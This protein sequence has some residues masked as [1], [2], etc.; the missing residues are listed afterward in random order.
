MTTPPADQPPPLSGRKLAAG[1]IAG[2]GISGVKTMLQLLTLPVLASLLRPA[3][4]G[5]FALAQP[6]VGFVGLLADAGLGAS[7]VREPESNEDVWSTAWWFLLGLGIFLALSVCGAGAV[8]GTLAHQPR[9]PALMALMSLSMIGVTMSVVPGARLAR[10]GRLVI[11]A[12]V[13]LGAI[14]AGFAVAVLCS[15]AGAGAFSFAAQGVTVTAVRTIGINAVAFRLPRWRF[16]PRLL[17]GHLHSGGAQLSGR[18]IDLVDRLGGNAVLQRTIGISD[19]GSFS[20]ASQVVRFA[21]EAVGNTCWSLLFLQAARTDQDHTLRLHE[22]LCRLQGLLLLP[23]C[24]IGAVAAPGVVRLILGERWVSA[25]GLIAIMLPFFALNTISALA[26]AILLARN[27]YS[28]ALW[29][30]A[31]GAGLR[32][33]VTACGAWIGLRG[34]AIGTDAILLVQV[35]VLTMAARKAVGIGPRVI[36]RQLIGP[37]IAGSLGAAAFLAASHPFG[38]RAVG[39]CLSLTCAA[40]VALICL[41]LVDRER[42]GNDILM[43]RGLIKRPPGASQPGMA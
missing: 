3:D 20:F 43:L 24:L 4:F 9:L 15:L 32:L 37:C 29:N 34:V 27:R 8:I 35:V 30:G 22:R 12:G 14:T 17:R 2:M 13:E 38:E 19:L 28:I 23:A 39:L 25:A 21:T 40:L 10:R 26:T 6:I 31:L 33:C 11:G 7:L 5:L 1:G 42:T 41:L 18:L 36:L 16:R